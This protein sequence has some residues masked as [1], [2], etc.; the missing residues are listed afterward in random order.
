MCVFPT[1][2]LICSIRHVHLHGGGSIINGFTIHKEG[3]HL[4]E[5]KPVPGGTCEYVCSLK[6]A[7]PVVSFVPCKGLW[8]CSAP[9]LRCRWSLGQ[10]NYSSTDNYRVLFFKK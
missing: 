1:H 3:C 10:R 5:G 2:T 4:R 9:G 6:S 7:I 8:L